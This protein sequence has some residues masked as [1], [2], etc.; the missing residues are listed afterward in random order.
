M[1][2]LKDRSDI[3]P[4][5]SSRTVND[6]T[7]PY[8][9]GTG[10]AVWEVAWLARVYEGDVEAVARHLAAC[11]ITPAMIAEALKYARSYPTEI[12]PVLE[13]VEGMTEERLREILP[14][15]TVL[16]FD[17]AATDEQHA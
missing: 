17:P 5:V 14:G 8:L 7:E 13:L 12:D 6:K 2:T 9:P 4:H 15:M 16:T 3:F 10:L 11:P 1:A